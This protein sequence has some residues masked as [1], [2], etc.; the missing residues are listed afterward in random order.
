MR[1][2]QHHDTATVIERGHMR[3]LIYAAVLLVAGCGQATRDPAPKSNA[4]K[5]APTA[6]APDPNVF[7]LK[8]EGEGLSNAKLGA[9]ESSDPADEEL[10]VKVNMQAKTLQTWINN[11]WIDWCLPESKCHGSFNN[12]KLTY[13]AVENE[14]DGDDARHSSETWAVSRRDGKYSHVDE[15][16]QRT[17]GK[18]TIKRKVTVQGT[19]VKVDK[20]T[21][22]QDL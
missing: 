17:P 2:I 12:A 19:C 1:L 9:D 18:L 16:E 14:R 4:R 6:A 7:I 5:S 20:P 11:R 10:Y 8:C 13:H 22:D 15:V 3:L 21:P